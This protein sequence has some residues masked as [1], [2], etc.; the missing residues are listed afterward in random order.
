MKLQI[1]V[2]AL[3]ECEVDGDAWAPYDRALRDRFERHRLRAGASPQ[4]V[5][6]RAGV[7]YCLDTERMT[8]YRPDTGVERSVRRVETLPTVL[9][10]DA[11]PWLTDCVGVAPGVRKYSITMADLGSAV[12]RDT[13]EFYFA[14]AHF[15]RLV[16]R[17]QASVHTVDVYES[18]FTARQ[19]A[20]QKEAFLQLGKPA[21][22]SWIF[23]GTPSLANI[24]PI[25]SAGFKVGGQDGHPVAVGAA[26]GQGFYSATG[27]DAPMGYA[28]GAG[29]VIL[30]RALPGQQL[31]GRACGGGRGTAGYDS[32]TPAGHPDWL[33]VRTKA[34]VLPCYVVHYR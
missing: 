4:L 10:P 19:F 6:E 2:E 28:Q 15:S 8:Q 9:A 3:W 29:C 1:G 16:G 34:Q 26:F 31:K 14:S 32:W 20:A 25:M 5:F 21:E 23:H 12:C 7:S 27:P 17:Q 13:R 24:V 33:I 22:E 18:E 30:A 11:E